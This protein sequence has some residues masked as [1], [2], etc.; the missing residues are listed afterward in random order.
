[1]WE[2]EFL[3]NLKSHIDLC[4][5]S[6]KMQYQM[7]KFRMDASCK[8]FSARKYIQTWCLGEC[9]FY[10]LPSPKPPTSNILHLKSLLLFQ[11][12]IEQKSRQSFILARLTVFCDKPN[13]ILTKLSSFLLNQ[14]PGCEHP[15]TDG[16]PVCIQI[17]NLYLR[18]FP[19]L[20]EIV[21][22][23]LIGMFALETTNVLSL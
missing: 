12:W 20:M 14:W 13:W 18:P 21:H 8:M 2:T 9:G 15:L 23:Y 10:H 19:L 3:Q 22:F 1:M 7:C 4:D 5:G 16:N 11:R 6:Q 17:L